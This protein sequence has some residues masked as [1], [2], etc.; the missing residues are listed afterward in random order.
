M[1]TLTKRFVDEL[2]GTGTRV[3]DTRKTTPGHR[4]LEKA[5]VRSGGGTNHRMGLYDMVLI[6][7][8]H[9]ASC[10]GIPEAVE[11]VRRRNARG[12]AVEVEVTD[13]DQ[14]EQALAAGVD[15]IL[16]DNM[17]PARVAEAVERV[18]EL[19]SSAPE[20][21]ASGSINL[22][23]VREYGLAGVDYVSVGALTHSAPNADF[24]MRIES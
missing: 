22:A 13:R 2:E 20:L 3:L 17:T 16:L 9:I 15:R 7:D 21:E 1:A 14:L 5:A 4:E 24:S 23:N 19:G 6:K 8:N 12:L 11:A 10:G 18:K